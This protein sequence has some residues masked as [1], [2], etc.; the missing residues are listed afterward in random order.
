MTSASIK[1]DDELVSSTKVY[2]HEN[3]AVV[4]RNAYILPDTGTA[5]EVN[6]FTPDNAPMTIQY[7]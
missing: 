1:G 7:S 4:E 3:M 5:A 2:M 6:Y